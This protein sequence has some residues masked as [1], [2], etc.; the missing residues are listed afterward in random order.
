MWESIT[1]RKNGFDHKA[2]R[3]LNV[4]DG[5]YGSIQPYIVTCSASAKLLHYNG[6]MKPWVADRLK[7][8]SPACSLPKS[9]DHKWDW[10]KTV[11]VYCD[12]VTFVSCSE[13]WQ[14]FITSRAV[15]ALKDF[16]SEWI[17]EESRWAGQ[18]KEDREKKEKERKDKAKKAK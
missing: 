15:N 3:G 1:L 4:K 10:Q 18:K 6:E 17:E 14:M 12:D 11:R 13:L 5:A 9:I 8:Q 2:L 16:E 7:R